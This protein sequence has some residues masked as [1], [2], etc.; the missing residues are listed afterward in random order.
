MAHVL[1]NLD[2]TG[3][4]NH[5]KTALWDRHGDNIS[6]ADHKLV[7]LYAQGLVSL[8]ETREDLPSMSD[9][10]I[11]KYLSILVVGLHNNIIKGE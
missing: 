4:R 3:A 5:L 8:T 11:S 2:M 6:Q 1:R 7:T 10:E 9:S